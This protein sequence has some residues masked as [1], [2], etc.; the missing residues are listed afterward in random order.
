[1][2]NLMKKFIAED[3]GA[4]MVEYGIMIALVAA[5]AIATVVILGKYVNGAF[6]EVNTS[7]NTAGVP[8]KAK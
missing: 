8:Q 5:V 3:S 6:D 7:M 2:K 1:M 4:A